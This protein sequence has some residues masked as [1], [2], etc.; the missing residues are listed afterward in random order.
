MK[1]K[2]FEKTLQGVKIPYNIRAEQQAQLYEPINKIVEELMPS[3]KS[4]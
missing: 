3:I 2:E 1:I 4:D